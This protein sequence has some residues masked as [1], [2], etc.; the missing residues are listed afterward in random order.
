MFGKLG[1]TG[2]WSPNLHMIANGIGMLGGA[3]SNNALLQL[4]AQANQM[5]A[6]RAKQAQFAQLMK[7]PKYAG[8]VPKGMQDIIGMLTPQQ[9]APLIARYQMAQ[10][11]AAQGPG[12]A[13]FG[14]NASYVR[15]PDGKFYTLQV[16]SDGSRKLEPLPEG[17]SPWRGVT[18]VDQGN[19]YGVIGRGS[20]ENIGTIPKNLRAAEEEKG[21]GRN[22]VKVATAKPL[23]KS[24]LIQG[25]QQL[26]VVDQDIDRALKQASGWTTGT[27]GSLLSNIP[28]TPSYDLSQTLETIR[29]NIGFDKL[30][31]MRN[32]SP[33]GGALGQVSEFEN[34]LLQSVQ[35]A[36]QQG[37][38]KGQLISNLKRVQ[39]NLRALQRERRRAYEKQYG[40]ADFSTS[41]TNPPQQQS[42]SNDGFKI[43]GRSQ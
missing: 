32:A 16:G 41:Y 26:K 17:M 9:A 1:R 18:T 38:S 6:Q 37:Q 21:L 40:K 2:G 10:Q 39:R 29:A 7:D 12:P 13:S 5:R 35:G 30:Q 34:R 4:G 28:G 11:K 42:Q 43:L 19:Q 15:G 22:D 8:M 36:L 25:D 31:A 14:K 33:T 27:S 24:K 20:G 3:P 23:E